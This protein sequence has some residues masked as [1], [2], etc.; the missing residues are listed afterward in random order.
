MTGTGGTCS[1]NRVSVKIPA[2]VISVPDYSNRP[3]PEER[4]DKRKGE[5]DGRR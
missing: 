2:E 3:R 5:E 4:K 1:G